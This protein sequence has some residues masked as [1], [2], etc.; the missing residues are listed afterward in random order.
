MY[1]ISRA[2]SERRKHE[3]ALE[4]LHERDLALS[5]QVLQEFYWQATRATRRDRI[6][7]QAAVA[8][9]QAWSR[10]PVQEISL[11]IVIAALQICERYRLSYW[12]SALIAAAQTLG[13]EKLLSEDMHHGLQIGQVTIVN[14]FR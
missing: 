7:H 13:C 6:P 2:P 8:L 1:S 12:D 5:T 9:I 4:L 11:D 3:R 10:F 14:P